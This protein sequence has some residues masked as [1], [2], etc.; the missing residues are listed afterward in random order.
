MRFIERGPSRAGVFSNLELNLQHRTKSGPLL[1]SIICSNNNN[2]AHSRSIQRI[3]TS[4]NIL[5][6]NMISSEMER[7]NPH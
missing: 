2:L 5:I 6:E 4:D 1:I 3:V 7:A